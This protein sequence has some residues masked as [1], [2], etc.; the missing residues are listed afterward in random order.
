MLN[1]LLNTISWI[2]MRVV[3]LVVSF[4]AT[5]NRYRPGLFYGLAGCMVPNRPMA[6]RRM[7]A[8]SGLR[9]RMRVWLAICSRLRALRGHRR[10]VTFG[11][12]GV[13]AGSSG[14]FAV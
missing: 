7:D 14:G 10:H 6:R 2:A 4:R 3:A 13:K 5:V 1:A 8:E 12:R 9:G 11:P